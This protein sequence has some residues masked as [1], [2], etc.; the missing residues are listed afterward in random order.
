M[1]H[2]QWGFGKIMPMMLMQEDMRVNYK[3][4]PFMEDF[5]T[6]GMK[7]GYFDFHNF[8]S[9]N[10]AY[11]LNGKNMADEEDKTDYNTFDVFVKK[12]AKQLFGMT[13]NNNGG[14]ILELWEKGEHDKDC[15]GKEYVSD[16]EITNA[17]IAFVAGPE[18]DR[19]NEFERLL[20]AREYME[21][22]KDVCPEIFIKLFEEFL[23]FAN[24]TQKKRWDVA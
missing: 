2:K 10:G 13:D 12:Q 18:D 5:Y 1:Y 8:V 14:M 17:K 3:P 24:Y 21:Q 4:V 11:I 20:T 6:T 15:K 9:H 7:G 19:G 23:E 16:Y 22:W